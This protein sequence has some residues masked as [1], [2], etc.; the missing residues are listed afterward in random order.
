MEEMVFVGEVM[1]A[2]GSGLECSLWW[3]KARSWALIIATVAK[4]FLYSRQNDE[5]ASLGSWD[6]I[7]AFNN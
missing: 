5:L 6:L 2:V 1:R 7:T 4:K 3:T